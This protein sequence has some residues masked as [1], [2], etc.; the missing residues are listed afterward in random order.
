MI[1]KTEE[2]K[3]ALKE[4]GKQ[5]VLTMYINHIYQ[6]TSKQLKYVMVYDRKK[7]KTE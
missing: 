7:K 6:M 2:L 5:Y 4:K 1:I 3:K